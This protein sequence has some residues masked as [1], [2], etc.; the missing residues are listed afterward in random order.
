MPPAFEVAICN[1]KEAYFDFIEPLIA[2]VQDRQ[3]VR[4]RAR[5]VLVIQHP[6]CHFYAKNA[7]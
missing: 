2:K 6:S 7:H 3:A 5:A 4:E 1:L